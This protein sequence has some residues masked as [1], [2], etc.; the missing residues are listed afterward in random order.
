MREL[1][2]YAIAFAGPAVATGSQFLL[3]LVLLRVMPTD[4]FGH[5][6][7]LLILSQFALGIWSAL[8]SA[9]LPVIAADRDLRRRAQR[10]AALFT[11]NLLSQL[12]AVPL[13]FVTVWMLDLSALTAVLF[14][15]FAALSLLRSFARV[16]A[17]AGGHALRVMWS[18][19]AYGLV[20]LAGAPVLL[21]GQLAPAPAAAALLALAALLATAVFGADYLRRQFARP[22]AGFLGTYRAIWRQH[23][24]WSLLG[25][26]TTEAT[27]N[28]HAYIVTLFAGPTAFAVLAASALLTR[29]VTVVTSALGDYERA[30]MAAQIGQRDGTAL[31]RSLLSFRLV[32][33]IVWIGTALALLLVMGIMPQLIFPPQYPLPELALGAALWMAALLI[34]ALRAPDSAMM[35]GA[36]E[37]RPLARA[38]LWSAI[39]SVVSVAALLALASPVWSILGIVLGELVFGL[40]LW[41]KASAWRRHHLP[42]GALPA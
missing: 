27:T 2:S 34:R 37:F 31:A 18:D 36:G 39:V 26:L 20:V 22:P 6:A 30:H 12:V 10:L 7:F 21:F 16:H 3:T 13:F 1:R 8:F 35:Q 5:F 4:I 24:G 38:S 9:A 25:V 40:F 42:A 11:A 41:P 33:T 23:S 29:P 19:V 14:S 32:M 17:Y 28:A 15:L